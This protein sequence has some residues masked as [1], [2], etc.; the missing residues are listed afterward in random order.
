MAK[1]FERREQARRILKSY[2]QRAKLHG[3]T[4]VLGNLSFG[5]VF[6]QDPWDCGD[7]GC[8][9]CHS[10]PKGKGHPAKVQ[11]ERDSFKDQLDSLD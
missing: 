7:P 5:K 2:T 1:S 11:K 8:Q 10:T 4:H 3:D 9:Y 6:K